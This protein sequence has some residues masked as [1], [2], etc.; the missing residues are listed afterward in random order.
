[1]MKIRKHFYY[2]ALLK[3]NLV[4]LYAPVKYW[5]LFFL[6]IEFVFF[7]LTCNAAA[8]LVNTFVVADGKYIFE[9]KN[10]KIIDQVELKKIND[11]NYRLYFSDLHFDAKMQTKF[12]SL[13]NKMKVSSEETKNLFLFKPKNS[14]IDI[15]CENSCQPKFQQILDGLAYELDL[16]ESA[17]NVEPLKQTKKTNSGFHI[18]RANKYDKF[19]YTLTKQDSAVEEFLNDL[20]I[21]VIKKIFDDENFKQNNLAQSESAS[22]SF[23]ANKLLSKGEKQLSFQAFAKSLQLNPNNLNAILGLA[24]TA[25]NKDEQLKFYL[26]AIDDE[27]LIEVSRAWLA[28]GQELSKNQDIAKAFI[29]YQFVILKNPENPYYRYE[30][31]QALE[32]AGFVY[33]EQATKRYLEAA[34]LAKKDFLAG[35]INKKEVLRKSTESLIKLLTKRGAREEAVHYC[36]SYLTMGF[37]EFIDGR[38]IK[39]VIK[40]INSNKNPFKA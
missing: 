11:K 1:M 33:F 38:S 27:A 15:Q 25:N 6:L 10:Q 19:L 9:T 29:S 35:D 16:Q 8:T 7:P 18:L 30:Y 34:V 31:A 22:L 2:S 40:E 14:F 39:G 23:I 37:A 17:E 4:K 26:K 32:T 5:G 36:H 13:S 21:E 3:T 24:K 28:N 20:D 12:N